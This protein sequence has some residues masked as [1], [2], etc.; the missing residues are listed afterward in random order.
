MVLRCPSRGLD[1]PG[2]MPRCRRRRPR[3]G[4]FGLLEAL[5][6][7][8]LFALVG[9]AL[10]AW[11]NTS[12]DT[13]A[14]LRERDARRP[15]EQM[16]IAWLQTRNPMVEPVG[17]ADLAPGTRV[18]WRAKPV[19]PLTAVAPLPGGTST[20]FRVALYAVDVVVSDGRGGELQFTLTRLG[21]ERDAALLQLLP[22]D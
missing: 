10:F 14:R 21:A 8:A 15:I 6:A 9:S 4:G 20:P 5:V 19:T 1:G 18:R 13:A 12:L 11:I 2:N 22:D 17:E 16:A 7:L 3:V